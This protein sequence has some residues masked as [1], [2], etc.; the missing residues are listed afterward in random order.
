M[1]ILDAYSVSVCKP[2]VFTKNMLVINITIYEDFNN[3]HNKRCKTA[4]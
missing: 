4:S 2:K 3:F 1:H